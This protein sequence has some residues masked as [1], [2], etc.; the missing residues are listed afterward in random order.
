MQQLH[1]I[2][3]HVDSDLWLDYTVLRKAPTEA[4]ASDNGHTLNSL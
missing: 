2:K 4:A 3:C 1:K